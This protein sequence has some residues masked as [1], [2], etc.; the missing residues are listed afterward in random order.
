MVI[1]TLAEAKATWDEFN[2][3]YENIV[4]ADG[5]LTN[6]EFEARR[7]IYTHRKLLPSSKQHF[8]SIDKSKSYFAATTIQSFWCKQRTRDSLISVNPKGNHSKAFIH[9]LHHQQVKKSIHRDKLKCLFDAILMANFEYLIFKDPTLPHLALSL[10]S[11][12][13]I[14][15]QQL[16]T[17]LEFKQTIDDYIFIKTVPLL[18]ENGLF[19]EEG[20]QLLTCIL[21]Y[22]NRFLALSHEQYEALRLLILALPKSEQQIYI[23][24]ARV[25]G[26][27]AKALIDLGSLVI[28]EKQFLHLTAGIRDAIGLIRFGISRYVRPMP[29]LGA[30][31]KNDIYSGVIN[32]ARYAAVSYP[33]T[34]PYDVI[35]GRKEVPNLIAN[36]HDV[37]HS[38]VAS[39]L[40]KAHFDLLHKFVS[41]TRNVFNIKWSKELWDW[42]D[43]D[44][45]Y[46]FKNQESQSI[47]PEDEQQMTE[48]F[49]KFLNWG[50][51]SSDY[52]V[53]SGGALI[54]NQSITPIGINVF[55]DLIKNPIAWLEF[56]LNPCYLTGI[57][58]DMYQAIK[59]IY[60]LI[61]HDS[62]KIQLLKCYAFLSLPINTN[63]AD[64]YKINDIINGHAGKII[65]KLFFKKHVKLAAEHQILSCNLYVNTIYL[66][67]DE[68]P[69]NL[70]TI[71]YLLS[72]PNHL[73]LDKPT[74]NLLNAYPLFVRIL[75]ECEGISIHELSI[76]KNDDL[77][78][79]QAKLKIERW[80]WFI[81][82]GMGFYEILSFVK[83][84]SQNDILLISDYYHKLF[85][86]IECGIT[87]EFYSTFDHKTKISF[88]QNAAGV[89]RL[90][91]GGIALDI[92]LSYDDESREELIEYGVEIHSM[93]E[94]GFRLSSLWKVPVLIRHELYKNFKEVLIL[95]KAGVFP[96][97]YEN[98]ESEFRSELRQF[99]P[100]IAILTKAGLSLE[101]LTML[102]REIRL[103]AYSNCFAIATLVS[104][105]V[106]IKK[107]LALDEAL[108]FE[109]FTSGYSIVELI[110][111]GIS[112]DVYVILDFQMRKI[113]VD[114][115][116]FAFSLLDIGI[117]VATLI[118]L[119]PELIKAGIKIHGFYQQGLSQAGL[120][121]LLRLS[122]EALQEI[123]ALAPTVAIETLNNQSG[124]IP[125]LLGSA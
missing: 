98:F 109:V 45:L 110:N 115:F 102:N 64:I 48:Q 75:M 17:V 103:T 116:V 38:L 27:L 35:H 50:S 94:S 24:A 125:K 85:V 87:F 107:I 42:I 14:S 84:L 71:H 97:Q 36:N 95:A 123:L 7:A 92:I 82:S 26:S 25:D 53:T 111:R 41:L 62:I 55:I 96:D 73:T 19:T 113:L 54:R 81:K 28:A 67:W 18:S 46:Y 43:C 37:Y 65:E 117:T 108:I 29:C 22:K 59:K 60:P 21:G 30:L 74:I 104:N 93:H 88:L 49:C 76:L 32:R 78:Q 114:Y 105:N 5:K 33:N 70:A 86:L 83:A 6:N 69:V 90:I 61:E 3:K 15:Q 122:G 8:E 68:L 4:F 51:S 23:T 58:R 2:K 80:E 66:A 9:F 56:K 34:H 119:S 118:T 44:Y 20:K 72:H 89:N 120:N 16:F 91:L 47:N 13:L 124:Y 31:D 52:G 40:P 10:F 39:S 112:F 100:Y 99:A 121:H 79:Y 1:K 63:E 11:S 12:E 57:Y 106:S 101:K 77:K